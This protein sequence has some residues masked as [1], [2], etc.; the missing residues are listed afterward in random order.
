MSQ[1]SA[2]IRW[3]LTF[4]EYWLLYFFSPL[5]ILPEVSIHRVQLFSAYINLP[6]SHPRF[7][8]QNPCVIS[9][10][11]NGLKCIL[12]CL[13]CQDLWDS[14]MDCEAAINA[15][16]WLWNLGSQLGIPL[17]VRWCYDYKEVLIYFP[18][19]FLGLWILFMMSLQSYALSA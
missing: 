15:S 4:G 18:N 19:C 6:G 3:C 14:K 11:D 10:V 5:F 1:L 12:I 7:C 9:I 17:E 16:T 13:H 8:D 2:R